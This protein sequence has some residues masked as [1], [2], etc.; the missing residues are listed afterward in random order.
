M[1]MRRYVLDKKYVSNWYKKYVMDYF[2]WYCLN[3]YLEIRFKNKDMFCINKL[4]LIL[5]Y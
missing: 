3:Y 2:L 5:I 4:D 1:V